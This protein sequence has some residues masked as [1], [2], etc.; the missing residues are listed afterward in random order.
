MPIY[1]YYCGSCKL[2]FQ[3]LRS[4]SQ[5]DNVNCKQC[6]QSVERLVSNFSFKSNTFTAPRLKPNF[7]RP[8]RSR[9]V[10]PSGEG[11]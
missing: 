10:N 11:S 6:G 4:I 7:D 5:A 8:L 1:E 3:A 2:E 9:E